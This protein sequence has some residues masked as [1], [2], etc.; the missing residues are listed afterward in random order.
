MTHTVRV[1]RRVRPEPSL[2][3][4]LPLWLVY[5]AW[6]MVL[7]DL[8]SLL[9]TMVAGPFFRMAWLVIAPLLV[10]ILLQ[11]P[12]VIVS[13]PAWVWYAP[14][15]SLIVI[16]AVTLPFAPAPT[17]AKNGFQQMVIYYALAVATTVFVRTPAHAL[18][19]LA[20]LVWRFAW[21]AFWARG[22]GRVSWHF[23]MANYDDFGAVMVQGVSVCFWFG[24]AFSSKR[25][26]LLAF[27]LA[28]YCV[29][30]VVASFARG[31]FLAMVVVTLLI[32]L[33]SPR[34]GV[35]ALGLIGA[36]AI[37]ATSASLLF[38]EG[39]FWN[40]IASAFEEG[41]AEG[42]GA[43]RIALWTAALE[44]W[45][46]R[47]ILGAGA[48]NF[49]AYAAEIIAP[50]QI[51]GIEHPGALW[52]FNPHNVLIQMLSEF[53]IVGLAC[54]IWIHVDFFRKNRSL[55]SERATSIWKAHG[56][57]NLN[58]RYLSL[59]LEGAMVGT[60]FCNMLYSG[61]FTPGFV[62]LWTANRLLWGLTSAHGPDSHP[63]LPFS[64]PSAP[65]A[66]IGFHNPAR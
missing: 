29:I 4:R 15:F 46:E 53:G 49:G 2:I 54:F 56:V 55:R 44:V 36:A 32:W 48:S 25:R 43:H 11:G 58:L 40:E 22:D 23:T 30:G 52:G 63:Q 20:M 14:F 3:S 31:A 10:L 60:L 16:A 51:E 39:Y 64:R 28:A 38:E 65:S 1:T 50:G 7:F 27:A 42:T 34:K 57:G 45:K 35:T 21:W 47:P 26:K 24:M 18:P 5:G 41:T 9:G 61:F 13:M 6:V 17:L 66:R 62:T 19:I 33:R 8:P 12:R 37:V 59:A